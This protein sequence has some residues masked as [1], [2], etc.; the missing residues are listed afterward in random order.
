MRGKFPTKA[1][2]PRS[3]MRYH[4]ASTTRQAATPRHE[5]INID[6]KPT[7]ALSGLPI[8]LLCPYVANLVYLSPRL[9]RS[10]ASI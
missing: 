2:P 7:I 9:H 8:C 10:V 1:L 4:F 6:P 3:S 5:V